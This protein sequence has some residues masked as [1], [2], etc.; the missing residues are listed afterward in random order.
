MEVNYKI[1]IFGNNIFQEIELDNN[2]TRIGTTNNC[3]IRFNRILYKDDFE[4]GINK[5]DKWKLYC[6]DNL[7]IEQKSLTLQLP[8]DL[9]YG[10]EVNVR[11][12]DSGALLFSISFNIDFDKLQHNYN[13]QIDISNKDKIYIGGTPDCDIVINNQFINTDRICITK[14]RGKGYL[15]ERIE[16][17][18]GIYV[19]GF[20]NDDKFVTLEDYDFFMLDGCQFY[21]KYGFLYT[22]VQDVSVKEDIIYADLTEQDNAMDYP[23]FQRN[24]RVHVIVPEEKVNILSPKNRPAVPE[25]NIFA[26]IAPTLIAAVLMITM[27]SMMGSNTM[28]V[29]YSGVMMGMGVITSLISYIIQGKK[30]KKDTLAR[31]KEYTDYAK[32]QEN[33]I[34]QLRAEEEK[35]LNDLYISP[36]KEVEEVIKFD[37]RL[38]EKE[39]S[40]ID[41]LELYLG[42]G[43]KKSRCEVEFKKQDFKDTEDKLIEYPEMLKN[44][45][46]Y[47]DGIPITIDLKKINA[48]GVIGSKEN[49]YNIL[50]NITLDIVTRHF[51]DDVKLYYIISNEDVEKFEW[52]RWLK[53]VR[54]ENNTYRNFAYDDDSK[55]FMFEML[56]TDLSGRELMDKEQVNKLPD[57]IIFVYSMHDIEKHPLSKYIKECGRYG[58][59]FIFFNEYQ[60]LIPQGCDRFIYVDKTKGMVLNTHNKM[61]KEQFEYSA[62]DDNVVKFLS[63]KL[64]CVEVNT[65]NLESTLTNNITLY[66]LLNIMSADDLDLMKRWSESRV[67]ESMVAPLGV[68]NGGEI[69]YLDL[70][71][72][73][74]GPHGL[75]AGTTG[76]GK[77]EILQSYILSMATLYHPYEVSFV[78]ID[79]KGGGMVNQFKN[80]PHLIGS[81]TNIDGIEIER[82]LLSIKA[83]LTKRQEIFAEYNVNHIDAYIK[84]YRQKKAT[85]PLPHLILIVDEFAELKSNQPEFMKELISASRIGRSLGVHLILATQKPSG[86]VDEQIWSNS[87]FRL[88]LKVQ[89]KNDSNE[90]IKSPLAAEIKEPGRAYFQVGNNEIFD[91]FQS[92]YSGAD[93]DADKIGNKKPFKLYGLTLNGQK[94]MLYEQKKEKNVSDKTQL[95]AIVEYI[96]RYCKKKGI[97]KLPGICLP[98]LG[99]LINY[100][101]NVRKA[102]RESDINICLGIYDDPSNQIQDLYFNNLTQNNTFI[103]GSSQYGKTNLLEV[104]LRNIA[105][106]YSPQE[107]NVYIL[108]FASMILKTFAMMNHVGGVVTVSDD[109]KIKS[110][111]RMMNEEIEQRKDILSQLGLSSYSAYK[112]AGY[113]ELP[114]IIIMVDNLTALKEMYLNNEDY[115]LPICREG[116]AVGISIIVTNQQMIGMG[117]KYLSNFSNRIAFY[118][119][120]DSE[121]NS[122]F[123]HCRVQCRNIPGRGLFEM[124]N[125]FYEFQSYLAF[126]GEKEIDRVNEMR[127]FIEEVNEKYVGKKAKMIPEIPDIITEE[128]A[129]QYCENTDYEIMVGL[130]YKTILPVKLNMMQLGAITL[131]GRDGLGRTNFIENVIRTL[132]MNVD[133]NPA[134]VYVFDNYMRKMEYIQKYSVVNSY[135]VDAQDAI[136]VINAVA[137]VL[138]DRQEKMLGYNA[139]DYLKEQPYMLI[140]I[141]DKD[142]LDIIS[143]N[144]ECIQ[145]FKDIIDKYKKLKACIILSNIDNSSI[146]FN[147]NDIMKKIKENRHYIIF[148]DMANFKIIEPPMSLIK[149]N[150]KRLKPGDAYYVKDNMIVKIRTVYVKKNES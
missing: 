47:I 90:V 112:D 109:E 114:Q 67:Y 56:Y 133:K 125:H 108:D 138:K 83:E 106:Q 72:K 92:A 95:N 130:D 99:N 50:K 144:K 86:V 37:S 136:K 35:A 76:S 51:Y 18:Y 32:K 41:Y 97:A 16:T 59:T 73:H 100:E 22:S 1:I 110:F 3:N 81:I 107:V 116:L 77:S 132:N 14:N 21:I 93:I 101:Y 49:Q 149:E 128:I 104:V 126:Q 2:E 85:Q 120:D 102:E 23:R 124:D 65:V 27:R 74:H 53:N 143:K 61:M 68:K 141:N 140:V 60:E 29:I 15:L 52:I 94:H 113:K 82:S 111:F 36:E 119:N 84:L 123:N 45:Y 17:R 87:K 131:A 75:V 11:Y 150:R 64:G 71:E 70:N 129:H 30:Y 9:N 147:C 88:C 146:P 12:K 10:M 55:K 57:K 44:E 26:T 148:D 134:F 42:T 43:R 105:S 46:E 118:C 91:L 24:S 78:I 31:E 8:I 13:R 6:S 137:E 142:M 63:Q 34:Q 122:L 38:F 96:D 48:V 20:K 4:I 127:K 5:E 39:K 58:Y 79:F 28:F 145:N 80:L 19:N 7:Y 40:D 117:Y 139:K 25:K 62:V 66:K 121:Y 54:N 89:N 135:S 103:L 98:G 33:K 69:V 115:F